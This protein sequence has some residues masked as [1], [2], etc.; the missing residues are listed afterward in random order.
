ME[1][2]ELIVFEIISKG[3]TAKGLVYEALTKSEEGDFDKAQQL[4]HLADQE[5]K[6]A[7]RIQTKLIQEEASGMHHEVTVLFVHA[8]DHLMTAIEV[9]TL[10]ENL[11]RMN[12]RLHLI[13]Q[14]RNTVG[15]QL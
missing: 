2:L 10:A 6:E 14:H 5:L 1:G 12:Q 9:R 7:H 8:Q 15:K 4:L 11:I 3:G 13:E